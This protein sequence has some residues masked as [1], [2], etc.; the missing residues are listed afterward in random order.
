MRWSLAIFVLAGLM[1]SGCNKPGS[2]GAVDFTI[3]DLDGNTVSL[4]QYRGKTVLLNIW[5][6]WCG[7]CKKEI[8]DLIALH[9]E[10]KDKDVVVLGVL[11]ESESAE[12]SKPT[13][14]EFNINYPVWYGDDAFA[15]QFQVQAFPTTVIIDKN[16]KSVKTMIGLQSK[17]KFEAAVREALM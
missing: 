14:K 2:G 12:A 7:P 4:S 1:S 11:L 13:V 8:P 5:A 10:M 3:K 17:A 6:T 16:G 15:Q 9:N